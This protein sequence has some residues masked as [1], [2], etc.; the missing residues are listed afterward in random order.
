MS[1]RHLKICRRKEGSLYVV[2]VG[3]SNGTKVNGKPIEPGIEVPLG[4]GDRL[5]LGM[6]TS[7][8]VESR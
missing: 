7:I 8:V 5:T 1:S 2:D 4:P 3:S 6:W